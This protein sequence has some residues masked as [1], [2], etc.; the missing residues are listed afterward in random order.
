MIPINFVYVRPGSL[1]EAVEAYMQALEE[2]RSPEYYAGG[3][4]VVSYT[5]ELKIEPDVVIDLKVLPELGVQAVEG[6]EYVFGACLTLNEL[7]E[8]GRFPLLSRAAQIVDH[9]IRN[10]LTLGGNIAGRLPYRETVLPFLLSEAR[11][12]LY[13]PAGERVVP[14]SEVF[15][16]RLQLEPGELL[17]QL[18]VAPGFTE[19]PWFY[20]R[21]TKKGRLDYPIVTAAFLEW[22]GALRMAT[23]GVYGFP[24]RSAEA[25]AVLNEGALEVGERAARVVDAVPF[26]VFDDLRASAA[27]RRA[28]TEKAIGEALRALGGAA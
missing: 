5:R 20:R 26:K 7:V 10:R 6:G 22:E 27:Y 16:K 14:L 21:R 3:T 25:E 11:V 13:G 18:L 19:A 4:E 9:T 2:G 8:G 28:L 23:S 1:E 17:V 24:L 15:D 12:R